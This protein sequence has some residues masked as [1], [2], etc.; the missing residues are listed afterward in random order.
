MST[1]IIEDMKG[2]DHKVSKPAGDRNGT[3]S[4]KGKKIEKA[5]MAGKKA[6]TPPKSSVS[7]KAGGEKVLVKKAASAKG[8]KI[9]ATAGKGEKEASLSKTVEK[10]QDKSDS[11][12]ISKQPA[13]KKKPKNAKKQEIKTADR[14]IPEAALGDLS[15]MNKTQLTQIC[16]EMDI[17]RYEN[18]NLITK[19]VMI[20][21]IKAEVR[22]IKS[23]Q[24]RR[25]KKEEKLKEENKKIIV[26]GEG[27]GDSELPVRTQVKEV[28][29]T[30]PENK[31]LGS[32]VDTSL[33]DLLS[34]GEIAKM[35][36]E[37]EEEANRE[38]K[39]LEKKENFHEIEDVREKKEVNKE[40]P[41]KEGFFARL[42]RERAKKKKQ[43]SGREGEVVAV[44][45]RNKL[46]V[47]DFGEMADEPVNLSSTPASTE[48]YVPKGRE[49]IDKRGTDENSV[50]NDEHT[51]AKMTQTDVN[52]I[53]GETASGEGIEDTLKRV[54]AIADIEVD[55]A[56]EFHPGEIGTNSIVVGG[57]TEEMVFDLAYRM[58]R[59]RNK[60][61]KVMEREEFREKYW[62]DATYIHNL[63]G[64]KSYTI[65]ENVM[66]GKMVNIPKKKRLP[67]IPA[68]NPDASDEQYEI[69]EAGRKK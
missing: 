42:R 12:S 21:R 6:V 22:K 25:A 58:L 30:E 51:K 20:S 52:R 10:K 48:N 62:L 13:A 9:P 24:T 34:R 35:M 50:V 40:K 7:A 69:K 5:G 19:D 57:Y 27:L 46:E 43:V 38:E 47:E 54:L 1:A 18:G 68:D 49:I 44:S 45:T 39:A 56:K 60:D 14:V 15:S 3:Y 31:E 26:S 53:S 55:G 16:R 28:S 11:K 29:Q 33:S 32:E 23:A 66:R 36:E 17:S 41:K 64:E 59:K 67:Y 4:G 37:V 61:T 2:T 63:I 8:K 65:Y